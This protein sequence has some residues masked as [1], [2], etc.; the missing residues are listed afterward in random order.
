MDFIILVFSFIAVILSLSVHEYAH[1][2]MADYLGD[3]TAKQYGRLTLNPLKHID[4]VG[5]IL[6]PLFLFL[7]SSPALFGYAKPVPFNPF[8]LRDQ[9][10][11]PA[12]VG[13]AGPMANLMLVVVFGLLIRFLPM[14]N[15]VSFLFII[16]LVNIGLMVFNLI[17]IPPL[18]GSKL[19]YALLPA[20][21]DN[22]KFWLERYGFFVLL[23][24]IFLAPGWLNYILSPIMNNLVFWLTGYSIA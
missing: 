1:A 22:F 23:G 9:K 11:G 18:D 21:L 5:T 16:V 6:L 24:L 13:L 20:S 14:S 2:W 15:L 7:A 12:W 10:W 19:V 4:L 8:N 17:P 3:S